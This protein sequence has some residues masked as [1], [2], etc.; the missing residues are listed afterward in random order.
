[1]ELGAL[2]TA[3][4]GCLMAVVSH[5]FM[6]DYVASMLGEHPDLIDAILSNPD[7]L[8]YGSIITV[9][10]GPEEYR[11][12]ITADAIDELRD[13]IADNRRSP[14]EWEFFLDNVIY[15]QETL[16]IVKNHTA[17]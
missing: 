15:D 14:E 11:T 6:L 9:S 10:S 17:R 7:N 12:A 16:E 4:K 5:V 1:M 3:G 13:L 8:T 2:G